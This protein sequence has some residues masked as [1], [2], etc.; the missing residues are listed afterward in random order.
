MPSIVIDSK[1]WGEMFG[2]APMRAL[3]TDQA[4]VQRY[5][6]VEAALARAQAGVGIVPAEAAE[7]IT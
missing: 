4:M 1:L 2:A 5:L 7:A 6:D 3:F